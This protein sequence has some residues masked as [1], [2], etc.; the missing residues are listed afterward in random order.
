MSK[1]CDFG[2]TSNTSLLV[3]HMCREVLEVYMTHVLW[4]L[5]NMTSARWVISM[6]AHFTHVPWCPLSIYVVGQTSNTKLCLIHTCAVMSRKYYLYVVASMIQF[7]F[8]K[9]IWFSY[10]TFEVILPNGNKMCRNVLD[11][12]NFWYIYSFRSLS[13]S[14]E[15]NLTLHS[16]DMAPLIIIPAEGIFSSL[17]VT[18]LV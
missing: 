4:C 15:N 11:S 6:S 16:N 1:K 8:D 12:I 3:S 10:I 2:L 5:G 17:K 13:S 18:E 7:Y 9:S 14:A